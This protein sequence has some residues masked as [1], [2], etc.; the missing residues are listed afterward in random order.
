MRIAIGVCVYGVYALQSV[1]VLAVTF[2]SPSHI[3]NPFL[4]RN[5]IAQHLKTKWLISTHHSFNSV[6]AFIC[7]YNKWC[8]VPQSP[9]GH[10]PHDWRKREIGAGLWSKGTLSFRP[11]LSAQFLWQTTF[12]QETLHSQSI[13]LSLTASL[14]VHPMHAFFPDFISVFFSFFLFFLFLEEKY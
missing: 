9:S 13:L 10:F 3:F 8:F 4:T 2:T 14:S 6:T 11:L 12:K 7:T 5:S 1:R